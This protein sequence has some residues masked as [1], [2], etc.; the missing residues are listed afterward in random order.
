MWLKPGNAVGFEEML[1]NVYW[2]TEIEQ[3]AIALTRQLARY[4]RVLPLT[5]K[6]E[7]AN[8]TPTV[9]LGNR[10]SP[11]CGLQRRDS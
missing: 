11:A 8:P 1:A 7:M 9:P 2:E 4:R 6:V 5:K 10:P 3:A